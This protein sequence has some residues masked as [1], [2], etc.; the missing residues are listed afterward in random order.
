MGGVLLQRHGKILRPVAYCSRSLM[1]SKKNYA[2]IEKEL[3]ASVWA[4]E[5]FHIYIHGTE[6]VLQSDHKP[7]IPLIN[8]KTLADAPIRCQRI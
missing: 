6:F 4:C 5:K 7:L 1:P 2:Q 8:S 3:F